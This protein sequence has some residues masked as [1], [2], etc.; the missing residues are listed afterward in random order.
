[1]NHESPSQECLTSSLFEEKLDILF[2]ELELAAHWERPSILFAIYRS[3]TV[4]DR[5]MTELE[6]KLNVIGQKVRLLATGEKDQFDFLQEVDRLSNLSQ[7]ILF[8]N[9]FKLKD[10]LNGGEIFEEINKY[11]E[12]FIDNSLRAVFWLFEQDVQ[13]FAARATECW[14]LRHRVID[15]T[16]EIKPA[17]IFLDTIESFLESQGAETPQD[18][19]PERL[20]QEI[21]NLSDELSLQP[22]HASTLFILG[23]LCSRKNDHQNALSLLRT[24]LDISKM[25]EDTELQTRCL[26]ALAILQAKS[27]NTSE[28]ISLYKQAIP[29]SSKPG[30]IWKN[31]GLLLSRTQE[32]QQTIEAF[33]NALRYSP[34]DY[35]SWI[36][37]GNAYL[38][39]EIFDKSA[40]AFET[41]LELQ[42]ASGSAW[43]GLGK[44]CLHLGKTDRAMEA[45]QKATAADPKS[46]EAWN[47]LGSV[48][49]TRKEHERAISALQN[50]LQ[51]QPESGQTYKNLGIAEYERGNYTRAAF[52]FEQAIPLF[53]DPQLRS[54]LWK[55]LA[56]TQ[57]KLSNNELAASAFK[58]AERLAQPPI[59]PVRKTIHP[60]SPGDESLSLE[61]GDTIMIESTHMLETRSAKEWNDLG[62][63]YLK[64]GAYK[65]AIFA[66]TKA[67]EI[68][69]DNNWPYINNLAVANYH[70]GKK[71]GKR[72]TNQ[73]EDP[74]LWDTEEDE[75]EEALLYSADDNIPL[76]ERGESSLTSREEVP[77]LEPDTKPA[78]PDPL[79]ALA[80]TRIS[81]PQ[82]ALTSADDWNEMGNGYAAKGDFDNAIEAYKK[83]IQANP[84]YG[85]P[86]SNLGL[87]FF[88]KGDYRSAIVLYQKSIE[89][90]QST[91][92]KA[93]TLNRLG[94]AYRQSHKYENALLAY[95]QAEE[96]APSANPILDR[97]RYSLMQN[98][99]G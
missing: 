8:I 11:R 58:Q 14:Y 74:D 88:K 67:I 82:D 38:G 36:H 53:D 97:A 90:L 98:S 71:L 45:L 95:K 23:L 43:T 12:Y 37:L 27:G 60:S 86:Y 72:V 99:L 68:A 85:Q 96:L 51:L 55:Y 40:S 75:E 56:E 44:T 3:E 13:K 18:Q 21:E 20:Q 42:P 1:M 9:G 52:L 46:I 28:A 61:N 89:L 33:L 80:D 34:Q 59:S 84:E 94:D 76:P 32:Y 30:R 19:S 87:L 17:Q 10:D 35:S 92:E 31:I 22:S 62:N 65:K 4:R 64:S 25:T 57:L 77:T 81:L 48:Y 70:M 54:M 15:F 16:D 69:Q 41:A 26:K 7:S 83:S 6:N 5:T 91:Q 24:A 63:S 50:A 2:R 78:V 47:A 39:L 29:L 73:P 66:F 93:A 79:P 49:M